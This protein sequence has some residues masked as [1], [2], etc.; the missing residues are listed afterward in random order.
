MT[1]SSSAVISIYDGDN[2]VLR[3]TLARLRVEL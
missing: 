2:D 3:E 1:Y